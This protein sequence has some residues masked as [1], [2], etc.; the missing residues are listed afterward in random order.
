MCDEGWYCPGNNTLAQPPGNKCL[1]GHQ[2]PVGSYQ[3]EACASGFYQ[4]DPE[5]GECIM[6][7]AGTPLYTIVLADKF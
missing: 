4:P 3:Q 5:Q 7:P 2:C 1:P 6:C